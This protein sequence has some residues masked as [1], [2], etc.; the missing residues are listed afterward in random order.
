MRVQDKGN[1]FV[2]VSKETDIR[3]A[4]EQIERSSFTRL[5]HDPTFEHVEMV[6]SWA[7]KWY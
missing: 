4:K 7:E 5:D 6:K 2:V 3:K 1:R